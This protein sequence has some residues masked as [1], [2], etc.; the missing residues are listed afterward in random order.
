MKPTLFVFSA[1]DGSPVV[2]VLVK[3]PGMKEAQRLVA[4]PDR[5]STVALVDPAQAAL[6]EVP[7]CPPALPQLE[8]RRF[9]RTIPGWDGHYSSDGRY[10]LVAPPSGGM[11][12]LDLRST[13]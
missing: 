1:V 8:S 11:D 4:L 12:L 7:S 2:R 3:Y 6:L 13:L 5:P 10:G 9:V